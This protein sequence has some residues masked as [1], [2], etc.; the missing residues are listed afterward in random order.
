MNIPI[1]KEITIVDFDD[2]LKKVTS[3]YPC[4]HWIYRGVSDSGHKLIPTLGRLKRYQDASDLKERLCWEKQF[5]TKSY[6]ANNPTGPEFGND[7][8]G[9][10]SAQHHGAPTRLLDWTRSPLIAALFATQ[11]KTD[12]EGKLEVAN[13]D[14]AVFGAHIC[15]DDSDRNC[16]TTDAPFEVAGVGTYLADP[17]ATRPRVIAQ[18]SAFTISP[19]PTIPLEQQEST[20]VTQVHKYIIPKAHIADFQKKLFRLGIRKG[21]LFPDA[22]VAEL[23]LEDAL[24][25]S[26]DL[27]L[28]PPAP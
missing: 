24:C 20:L 16:R 12:F 28:T 19:D 27:G 18:Q 1:F 25:N 26:C 3:E 13:C 7:F 21:S 15:L 4:G 9:A 23:E 2:F 6:D 8:L 17:P 5:I 11:V 14:S 10:V 22:L